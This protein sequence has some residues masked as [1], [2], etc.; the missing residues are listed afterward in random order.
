MMSRLERI[1]TQRVMRR[2]MQRENVWF[3]RAE[4]AWMLLLA[5]VAG[6]VA[7]GF[8]VIFFVPLL[9]RHRPQ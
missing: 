2:F 6:M 3:E 7:L 9:R 5:A 4:A 8:C 1:E